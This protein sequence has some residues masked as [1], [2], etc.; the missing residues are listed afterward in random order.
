MKIASH[1]EKFW[2]L[3]AMKQRLNAKTDRELWI[4]TAMNA[5]THLLNAA[6]HHCKA[7]EEVDSFHTQVNGLYI[8]PDRLNNTLHD[9]MHAPGDVMHVNQP[10]VTGPL[11]PAIEKAC[12]SLQ[13]IEMLRDPYVRGM[14]LVPENAEKG[15]ESSYQQCVFQLSTVLGDVLGD[16]T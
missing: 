4:W 9:A 16:G 5:C 10:L 12:S 15:W 14:E 3:D 13:N 1:I 2:R 7:T 8:I 6:L 11:L